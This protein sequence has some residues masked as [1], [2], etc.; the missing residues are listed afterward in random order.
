MR[1]RVLL[2][3]KALKA[4][5]S[6]HP[7]EAERIRKHLRELER[8]PFT[9]RSGA[10]IKRLRGTKGRQDLYRIRMGRYRAIYAVAGEEVL[11]TDLFE[12]GAGYDV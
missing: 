7:E 8:D 4:L 3:P 5:R 10:G 6:L 2:H 12:R 9:R 11:V 1:F